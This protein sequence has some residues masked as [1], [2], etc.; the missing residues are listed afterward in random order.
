MGYTL[1]GVLAS[2]TVSYDGSSGVTLTHLVKGW[3]ERSE[4][5]GDSGVGS[6]VL[7][8]KRALVLRRNLINI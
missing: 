1:V 8:D 7:A 6:V 5:V 2:R 4:Y 3:R